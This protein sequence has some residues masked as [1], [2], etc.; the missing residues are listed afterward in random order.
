MSDLE[1]QLEAA[2][3]EAGRIV[4]LIPHDLRHQKCRQVLIHLGLID[5]EQSSH[6]ALNFLIGTFVAAHSIRLSREA[7]AKKPEENRA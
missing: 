2:L 3:A 4:E 7:D 5:D 1:A 6:S